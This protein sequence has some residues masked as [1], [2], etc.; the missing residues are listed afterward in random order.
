M[1]EYLSIFQLKYRQPLIAIAIFVTENTP[2]NAGKHEWELFGTRLSYQYNVYQVKDQTE[3]ALLADNNPFALVVLTCWYLMK[4]KKQYNLRLE[5]KKILYELCQNR[6]YTSDETRNLIIF[7]DELMTLPSILETDFQS[8]IEIKMRKSNPEK[9]IFTDNVRRTADIIFEGT[10]GVSPHDLIE[11]QSEARAEIKAVQLAEIKA[12]QLMEAKNTAV[13]H[14]LHD[15]FGFPAQVIA[16]ML[17][18]PLETVQNAL[19]RS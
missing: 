8:F 2:N 5:Y 1:Y 6:N 18:I 12:V 10:Y 4:T 9:S 3:A 19:N 13:I 14:K 11:Q 16:D 7:V 17:E 15:Q